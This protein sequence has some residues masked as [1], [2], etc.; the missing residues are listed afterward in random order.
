MKRQELINQVKEGYASIASSEG[1]QH[2]HQTSSSITPEVYYEK[3]LEKVTSEIRE[4]K[5]DNCHSGEEIINRVA[6]DKSILSGW[7]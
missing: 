5:F 7:S 2:F 6:A 4:G 3:L 1:Q